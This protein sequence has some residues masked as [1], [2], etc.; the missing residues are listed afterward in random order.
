MDDGEYEEAI[1]AFEAL[2]GY[3]DS[4]DKI[5]ECEYSNALALMD[6]GEYEEAIMAFDALG[7]YEDGAERI[8]ACEIEIL[9]TAAVD[10]IVYFGTYEQDN[11]TSNGAEAIEW[12]VLDKE[13]DKLLLISKYALD[14]QPYNSEKTD[15]TWESC[16]LR[17]WLNDD[18]L[19]TAFSAEE[20]TAIAL[21]T[22][23]ADENPDYDTDPGND[24]KDKVFLLS[25]DE[26]EEY[27]SSDDARQCEPT[28]IAVANGAYESDSGN[29]W[30][31]LRSPGGIQRS[32]A[33]VGYDGSV[34]HHG[35]YVHSDGVAVRPALWINLGA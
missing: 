33:D 26:V 29:C 10:D 30:W 7:D 17:T 15:V 8:E 16:T 19:N 11:N 13:G 31:W 28:D 2:D 1:A 20:Q 3:E 21:T 9:K 12:L 6:S 34:H 14:F 18:F 25:I 4:A 32:A 22:V 23:T 5:V 27:F 35:Y 24:T